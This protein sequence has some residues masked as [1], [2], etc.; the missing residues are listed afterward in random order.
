MES[1]VNALPASP[2]RVWVVSDGRAGIENQGLGLAEALGA[3]RPIALSVKRIG[4]RGQMGA[5]PWW[6]NPAPLRALAPGADIAPPWPDIW[7]AAGRATLP[8]SLRMRRWS[9]GQTFVVQLQD[10]RVPAGAFD[11]VI[12]PK[13][14]RLQGENVV[15]IVGA[16]HRVTPARLAAD[17]ARF[18]DQLAL[19][20]RPRVAV[21]IGGKSKAFGLSA[22]RAAA[23]A[24]EIELPVAQEGGSVMVTFSRRTPDDAKALLSARLRHLPGLIWDGEGDNPYFAF[25]AAADYVLVTEESTNM[26]TEAASTGKPVFIL[27]MEGESLKFRLYH[28]ELERLGAA[29]PFGGAFHSWTYEPLAE[30]ERAAAEV[31][32]RFDDRA[33]NG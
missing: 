20:P 32:R 7:I 22:E 2:L 33:G 15:P 24:H 28:E 29:R 11:L 14:D 25:L 17:Y 8:L 27:K 26:T 9:K 23:M 13:H 19:L 18:E 6:L 12:P 16:P 10:P 21:L 4:W 31:L 1:P 5:L 3:L 30:T